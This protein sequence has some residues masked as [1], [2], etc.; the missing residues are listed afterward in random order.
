MVFYREWM[1]MEVM[2][3]ILLLWIGIAILIGAAFLWLG[4]RP[5]ASKKQRFPPSKIIRNNKRKER[6]KR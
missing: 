4:P 2:D 1:P 5:G 3:S 6:K